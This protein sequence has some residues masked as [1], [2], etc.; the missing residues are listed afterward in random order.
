MAPKV[1][2]VD[3]DKAWLVLLKK[4]LEA[5]SDSFSVIAVDNGRDALA[6]LRSHHITIM[7][8]DLRMPEI[9]GFQLSSYVLKNYPDIS[10][11]VSTAFDRPKTRA[12][13]LKS[14]AEDYITK[15]YTATYLAEKIKRVLKKKAEGGSLHNVSLETYLQLVE[16]EQQTCTLRVSKKNGPEMGV[17]F[18]KDG[19][20]INAR[21]ADLRGEEA[22]YKILSWSGV[23]IMIENSCPDIE[24]A[25]ETGL[26]SIL[27]EAMRVKD[28]D[29][30]KKAEAARA[31]EKSSEP[32]SQPPPSAPKPEPEK[33]PVSP[34]QA[35]E[36]VPTA[37]LTV[38]TVRA[39]IE[40]RLGKRSGVMDIY[41]DPNYSDLIYQ[42]R[43]IGDAFGAGELNAVYLNHENNSQMV[44]VPGA[45]LV[46][47]SLEKDAPKDRIIDAF[48]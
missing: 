25:I 42:A 10:V 4:E 11:I 5:Y 21:T 13:V 26:Q 6:V 46:V 9:D 37:Q 34:R 31:V 29:D 27:L 23:S 33:P 8:T 48:L 17:L 14:G 16:M 2:I 36:P 7:V 28:E 12:V 24:R 38:D 22:A 47:V 44:L 45:E 35:P 41:T 3:D 15:P 18:F 20:L 43:R 1:L 40:G 39:R 32:P 30:E 19:E